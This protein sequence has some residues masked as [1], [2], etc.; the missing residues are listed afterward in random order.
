MDC[1]DFRNEESTQVLAVLARLD[2]QSP[3][4][5]ELKNKDLVGECSLDGESIT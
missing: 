4:I 3:W 1:C 5:F 2:V